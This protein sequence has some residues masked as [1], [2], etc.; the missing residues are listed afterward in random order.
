MK[1]IQV[2]AGL[3]IGNG[4]TKGKILINGDERVVDIPST[5]AYTSATNIPKEVNAENISD[6]VN[7]MDATIT[8]KAIK[9]R[10]EG[11]VYIG[12]RSISYGRS[13][14]VFDINGRETKAED[15]LSTVIVLSSIAGNVLE[16]EFEKEGHIEDMEVEAVVSL[17]L[18]IDD[19][20]NYKDMYRKKFVENSHLVV[21]NNFE[22]VVTVK[23]NFAEVVVLPEGA[24]AQ[25]AVNHMG[26]DYLNVI[27]AHQQ[28]KGRDFTGYTGD[29]LVRARNTIGID[30]G[31]GTVN[32]PVFLDGK[33]A[34]ENSSSI[35]RGYGTVLE[36]V[37]VE[38]R[39]TSDA[40]ADRKAL[41]NF[42][43]EM[44]S[45]LEE[46]VFPHKRELRNRMQILI[47]KHA[48]TLV[49]EIEN[50]FTKVLRDSGNKADVV[51]IYGGGANPIEDML[52]EAI[53]EKSAI[54]VPVVYI[55][56]RASRTLNRDGLTIIVEKVAMSLK[57]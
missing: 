12:K 4:Y 49:D 31:E 1:K 28:K 14:R 45:E 9:S 10:D 32:F 57:N 27:L 47:E 50:E 16:H 21:V 35:K 39:N 40:F 43:V 42:M 29:M 44:A 11:R 20:M 41:A 2:V 56:S 19:Y 30:V 5:Y 37:I 46:N 38:T 3:D 15:S 54:G 24:A 23:I 33:P 8:S 7:K 52:Y 53:K 6:L 26:A 25:Y 17:A 55:D 18:P 22:K 36:N 51:Y 13:R 34:V 48:K